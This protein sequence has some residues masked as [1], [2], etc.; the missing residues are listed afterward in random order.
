MTALSSHLRTHHLPMVG[1]A[2]WCK[3]PLG[4]YLNKP[5]S[6]NLSR[7]NSSIECRVKV[8]LI[9][10]KKRRK[11]PLKMAFYKVSIGC[12]FE[13]SIRTFIRTLKKVF[14]EVFFA[15]RLSSSVTH[16]LNLQCQQPCL[17]ETE[18]IST[19][20]YVLSASKK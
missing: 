9:Q 5:L 1:G 12:E 17:G 11:K 19:Y 14:S 3:L 7:K 15:G 6:R 2:R 16:V 4:S 8:F 20:C 18:L 13:D 10:P